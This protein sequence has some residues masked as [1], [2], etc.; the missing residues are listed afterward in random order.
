MMPM[1]D[2]VLKIQLD[3]PEILIF[4]AADTGLLFIPLLLMLFVSIVALIA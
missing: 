3:S 4:E 2:F 1:G